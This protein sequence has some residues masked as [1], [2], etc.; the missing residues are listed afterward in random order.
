MK[1]YKVKNLDC[2]SCALRIEKG[3]AQLDDVKFVSVNFAT[4]S[5]IIDTNNMEHVK[6]KIKE[7]EPDAELEDFSSQSK[8]LTADEISGNRRTIIQASAGV[9]LL[10]SG[11]LFRGELRNSTFF[12]L[13]F[14][15]FGLAYLVV[16]WKVIILAVKNILNKQ[17]FSE[18]FLMTMATLG[19]IAIGEMAEAV[20]VM[21]FYV[22]GEF[23]QD[24]SVNRSRRSVKSLLELKP[25][26]AGLLVDGVIKKVPPE[27]V[28]PG[29]R[30]AVKPGEKIPLD[31]EV[32]EGQSY[33]DTSALTRE[34]IPRRLQ[35][36]DQVLA[37]M[38]NHGGL[39][40]IRVLKSASDSSITRILELVEN[41]SAR[42]AET[43]RFITTFSRF[44]TPGVV[45]AA[46]LLAVVPPLLF[47]GQTF[48]TWIYRALVVLVVS[49]PCALVISIPLGYFGGIGAA[50]RKGILVKGSNYLDALTQVKLV[51]FDKTGTLTKGE[52]KVS[53][54]VPV[55]GFTET[56][57]LTYAAQA[58]A[59]SN[60]PIARSIIEASGIQSTSHPNERLQEIAGQ[61]VKAIIHGKSII[62]GNEKLMGNENI[63]FH[64]VE[65]R[66]ETV[67]Y[68]AIDKVYAGYISISDSLKEDAAD[69]IQKLKA[70]NIQ[71]MILTG[72]NRSSAE[73]IAEKLKI[74]RVYSD[75]LPEDKV[76][77]I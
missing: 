11:L 2:A 72:D 51:V 12:F 76:N 26:F 47:S 61:G 34:S 52:F 40:N 18:Y 6:Q 67:V 4:A 41:A 63:L 23:F 38:I 50:S 46:L 45:L 55:N 69:A 9:L 44:Y 53:K 66:G 70:Q 3:V 59:H 57:V 19:A 65:A 5:M 49:C 54:V 24:L 10:I 74:D 73:A 33:A 25:D 32:T 62:A 37:G 58:E 20:A 48:S 27:D 64:E 75:L 43:E 36:G 31:G 1:K 16:G 29:D 15:L 77:V 8:F 28:K 68:V 60:H 14:V 21:F 56:S 13:E 42:K 17:V 71:T 35:P 7:I 22:F 39:L 30:I